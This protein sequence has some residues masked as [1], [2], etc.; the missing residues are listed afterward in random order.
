MNRMF[1]RCLFP[2]LLLAAAAAAAEEGALW[3]DPRCTPIEMA[4]YGPFL[5]NDDGTLLTVDENVLRTSSDGGK[6]WSDGGAPIDAG[7]KIR[8]HGHVGQIVRAQDGTLVILFLDFSNYVFAWDDEKNAPKPECRLEL[9]GIRSTDGG[10]T[11]SDRQCLL[12]GYNAD[13]MGF[14]VLKGGRLVATV[15]HLMPDWCRWAACSFFSD[16]AGK[17]WTRS[18]WLDLGGRGHHDG[19]LEPTLIEQRD[20]RLMMFIRTNLDRFWAAWSDDQGRYWRTLQPTDI[21][22]SSAPAWV[23]R[24]RGGRLMMAWNPLAAEG[25]EVKRSASRCA[26]ESPASWYREELCIAFSDDDA[27]TWSKPAVIMRHPGKMLSY[28][29]IFERAPGEIWVATFFGEP[30]ASVKLNDADFLP[31]P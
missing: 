14:I 5:Q 15:E 23:T 27:K 17:T 24:L 25:A 26:S 9:C 22:A 16:D 1:V 8:A 18:N 13:F 19:T 29:Y 7:M 10:K 4:K 11:W 20:G 21:A 30:H 12:D 31:R 28:P 2:A 3:V 6:T